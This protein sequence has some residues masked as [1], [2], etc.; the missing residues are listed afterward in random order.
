[1]WHNI[2]QNHFMIISGLETLVLGAYL[3]YVQHVFILPRPYNI[4]EVSH[5]VAHAQDPW[6]DILLVCIGTI[7]IATGMWNINH[8]KAKRVSLVAM[9]TIWTTYLVAFIYHDLSGLGSIGLGTLL[10]AFVLIRLFGEAL[11]G[12]KT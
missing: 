9:I 10:I 1:M 5:I 11:W 4:G 8:Y 6:I 2:K 12:D 7:A 3:I